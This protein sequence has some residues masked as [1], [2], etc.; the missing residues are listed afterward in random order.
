VED[1]QMDMSIIFGLTALIGFI[2]SVALV[3]L[4]VL[5]IVWLVRRLDSERQP[6]TAGSS[7]RALE[8]A[9]LRYA[10]GDIDRDTYLRI[11]NDLGQGSEGR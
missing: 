2:F 9:E 11:R 5:A 7:R 6:S 10:R 8:E 3:V 4:V 1:P